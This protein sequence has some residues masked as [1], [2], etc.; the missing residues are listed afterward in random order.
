MAKF[1]ELIGRFIRVMKVLQWKHKSQ[2]LQRLNLSMHIYQTQ[3]SAESY[4]TYHAIKPIVNRRRAN[5]TV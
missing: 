5:K 1:I 3:S 2:T 4:W